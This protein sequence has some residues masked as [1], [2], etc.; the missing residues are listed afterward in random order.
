MGRIFDGQ[1]ETRKHESVQRISQLVNPYDVHS[2]R[3]FFFFGLARHFRA[4]I[5]TYATK[6]KCLTVLMQKGVPFKWSEERE[7]ACQELETTISSDPVLTLPDFELPFELTTD[8][9]NY[10]TCASCSLSEKFV[11]GC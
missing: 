3:V 2:R 7:E 8:A 1:T 4:F 5:K 11:S 9:S 10:G 6:R